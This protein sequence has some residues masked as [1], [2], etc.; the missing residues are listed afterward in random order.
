M[1]IERLVQE[2]QQYADTAND[3]SYEANA[4]PRRPPGKFHPWKYTVLPARAQHSPH[5]TRHSQR[6]L[7]ALQDW[8]LNC[9]RT[10]PQWTISPQTIAP[11]KS[12]KSLG[13]TLY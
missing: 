2:N 13:N 6:P 10:I 5:A 8:P 4:V 9:I 12:E 11:Q 3:M 1:C 7:G